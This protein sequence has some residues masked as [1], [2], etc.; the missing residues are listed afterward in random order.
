[1]DNNLNAAAPTYTTQNISLTGTGVQATPTITWAT[2]AAITYGTPLSSTQLN[3]SSTIAGTF[4][5]SPAVGAVLNARSQTLAVT[6]TPTDTADYTVAT[7]TTSI[8]ISA[9]VPVL[10]FAPIAAQ[11]YGAAPFGVSASSTSSGAIT[12]AVVSGPATISGN[13]VTLTGVGTV[14]LIA[15]QASSGNYIAA[16]TNT[17]FTVAAPFTLASEA[18]TSATAAA[19]GTA[20]YSFTLTPW[21]GVFP[22]GVAFTATG[23]PTGATATFSPATIAAGSGSTSVTLTIQTS[24]QTA[25]NEPSFRGVQLP[26]L[27]LGFLLLP[28]AGVKLVRRR[29]PQMTRLS[30]VLTV[31][32]LSLGVLLGLSGCAGGSGIP[33][34]AQSYNVVITAK[35]VTTGVQSS[36]NL[37]LTVQ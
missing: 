33:D 14:M 2:P 3:A 1:M 23:L 10:T 37:T 12:Y 11:T 27:S 24:S 21:S 26:P 19:G 34:S 5:Y 4:V 17:S 29:L 20:T 35:D 22:D 9:A 8:T 15:N 7:A 18:S 13:I 30:M 28:L 16:T 32:A 6:F 25:R 36:T 31:M